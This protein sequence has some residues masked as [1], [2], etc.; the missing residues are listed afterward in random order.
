MICKKCGSNK[1]W[2]ANIR[3]IQYY[4]NEGD[5]RGYSLHTENKYVR[6]LGCG[7]RI[8]ISKIQEN[9]SSQTKKR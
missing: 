2:Y 5:P 6:C 8:L 9:E 1:G 4:D 3:G 7:Y